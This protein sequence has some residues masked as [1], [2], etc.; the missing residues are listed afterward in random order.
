MTIGQDMESA[1]L[2]EP[3]SEG[4]IWRVVKESDGNKAPRPDGFDMLC[5]QKCWKVFKKD[6]L[7]FFNEFYANGCL[8][9]GINNSFITLIPK[10]DCPDGESQSAFIGG[11]S[12]L[13]GV[14][15]SNEVV[16][17]CKKKKQKG[18]IKECLH[19]SRVSILVNGSPTTEF[20][21][22]KRLRQ[23]DPMSPFLFNIVAEGLNMFFERAKA[24]GQIKGAVVGHGQ[25][26]VT[27]LQIADDTVVFCKAEEQEVLNV[28]RILRCF[29]VM[30]GLRINFHKSH[31]WAIGIQKKVLADFAVQL[32]YQNQKLLF[33]YLGL[34]L[35]AS[36][37]KRST[38]LPVINK[39]KSKLASWKRKSLSFGGRY[40]W[41]GSEIKKKLHMVK[42][43]NVTI[44]KSLGGLGIKRLMDFNVGNGMRVSFWEDPWASNRCLKDE[45][46][47]LCDLSVDKEVNLKQIINK[48]TRSAGWSFNFRR[49]LRAWEDDEV[50]RLRSYL[51]SLGPIL[52]DIDDSLVWNASSLG[53]F[54]INSA[55]CMS[56]MR[57]GLGSA[58]WI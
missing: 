41:R 9:K 45:F 16:D 12:I 38:W 57:Q 23:G 56:D 50:E 19:S 34:P 48:R 54:T 49:S 46:P 21:H 10:K 5:F 27:Y 33:M 39:F 11:R 40:L 35:G 25:I 26:I 13:D 28:K 37:K 8:A 17:W 36:P 42:W 6:I 51:T 53:M 20:S 18:W 22:E 47:K 32:N 2:V 29:E 4:E 55:Y 15:I 52:S 43:E 31:V 44:K 7:K 30:S 58:R 24:L 1:G 3:F 14:L